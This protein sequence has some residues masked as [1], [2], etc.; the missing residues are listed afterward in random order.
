M[1]DTLI[2][3]LLV[4]VYMRV[5]DHLLAVYLSP[6]LKSSQQVDWCS[7]TSTMH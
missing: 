3:H 4:C 2:F 7:L 6:C 5:H 1:V